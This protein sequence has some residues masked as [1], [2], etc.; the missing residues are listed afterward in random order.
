MLHLW[1]CLHLHEP[2]FVRVRPCVFARAACERA[3]CIRGCPPLCVCARARLWMRGAPSFPAGPVG[4]RLMHGRQV[5]LWLQGAKSSCVLS[6]Q[7]GRAETFTLEGVR[8]EGGSGAHQWGKF[9]R[10]TSS[11]DLGVLSQ[12]L[13]CVELGWGARTHSQIRHCLCPSGACRGCRYAARHSVAAKAGCARLTKTGRGMPDLL[14]ES[15]Q[16]PCRRSLN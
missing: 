14:E 12:G 6:S 1:A 9:S 3:L 15:R 7:K 11:P 5:R 8:A 10:K 13:L 4:S 16:A 2:V